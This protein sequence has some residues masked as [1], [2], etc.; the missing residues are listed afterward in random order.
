MSSTKKPLEV[1]LI[2]AGNRGAEVYGEWIR[3]NPEQL[4]ITAVAEP[5]EFRRTAVSQRHQIPAERQFSTWEEALAV[6]KLA[7]VAVSAPPS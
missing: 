3:A 2:G 6:G 1:L 7:D 5:I 4:K